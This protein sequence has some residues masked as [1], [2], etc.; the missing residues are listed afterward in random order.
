MNELIP[1]FPLELVVYPGG[2]LNLH[3]FEPR[4][5]QLINDC[6]KTKKTFGIP[7]VINRQVGILG[8][9]VQLKEIT[10]VQADGQMDIR[11]EGTQIFRV[12]KLLKLFP[13]KLYS[14][15]VVEFPANQAVG[16]VG[17]MTEILEH[18]KKLHAA[19]NV[20][21]KFSKPV[22]NLLSYDVAHHCGLSLKQEYELL[23]LLDENE[24]QEYLR[25]HLE[26]VLPVVAEM[27]LLKEKIQLNGHFRKLPGFE[28]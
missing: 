26:R 9:L 3:I 22:K 17:V 19:L 21:K 6:A 13:G 10:N 11:T 25:Q 8:T 16:E 24:R 2:A 18:I 7:P 23:E 12:V 4:Y 15:A 20:A 14:G 28:F 1:I 27:A 5:Q